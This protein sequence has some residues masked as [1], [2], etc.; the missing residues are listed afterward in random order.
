MAEYNNILDIHDNKP[1]GGSI[2]CFLAAVFGFVIASASINAFV[3][4]PFWN[5]LI[6]VLSDRIAD[7]RKNSEH[8]DVVAIGSSHV[9]YGFHEDTFDQELVRKR[10]K[11][12]RGS[13]NFG[14]EAL[15]IAERKSVVEL[16]CKE[17]PKHLKCILLEPEIRMISRAKDLWTR[18]SRF[19]FTADNVVELA[20]TKLIS[21]RPI[22][23]RF[24]A[25]LIPII[26]TLLNQANLGVI[27]DIVYPTVLRPAKIDLAAKEARPSRWLG[28]KRYEAAGIVITAKLAEIDSFFADGFASPDA[29]TE[30]EFATIARDLKNLKSLRVPVALVFP[31]TTEGPLEDMA[32][33]DYASK[34]GHGW[35]ISC[36]PDNT[37][38]KLFDNTECWYDAT[39]LNEKGARLF[40]KLLA[41]EVASQL[42][43]Q[44]SE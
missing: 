43:L 33:R 13:F 39:H 38:W 14:I 22:G 10:A 44:K 30:F 31:P 24:A 4:K 27:P 26:G 7:Y 18:R 5:P 9:Y 20:K 35:I 15:S 28:Q 34:L 17:P 37:A 29:F 1:S 23:K 32:I 40:S 42:A 21:N 19:F 12:T 8:I 11:P 16:I 25:S 41:D 3:T 6:P 2:Y 36:M